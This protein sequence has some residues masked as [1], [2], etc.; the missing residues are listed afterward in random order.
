VRSAGVTVL[1]E[2]K[3]KAV[4]LPQGMDLTAYRIVQEALTNVV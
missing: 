4:G 3:G 1:M 2:V